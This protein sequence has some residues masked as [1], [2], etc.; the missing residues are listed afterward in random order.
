MWIEDRLDGR[1]HREDNETLI[2][3]RNR[4][5]PAEVDD[6]P[7]PKKHDVDIDERHASGEAGDRVGETILKPLLSLL[8]AVALHERLNVAIHHPRH[9]GPRRV[10]GCTTVDGVKVVLH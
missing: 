9:F 1:N 8:G 7:E 3:L 5:D 10:I 6:N 4:W 2:E